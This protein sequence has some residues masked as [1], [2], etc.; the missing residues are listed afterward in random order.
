MWDLKK[1]AP[2]NLFIKQKKIHNVESKLMVTTGG[3]GRGVGG[4]NCETWTDV[5]TL[6]YIKEVTNKDLWYSTRNTIQYS[7]MAYM[8]IEYKKE[9][10][11]I[12]YY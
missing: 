2:V 8:G 11:S 9:W 5:Y 6:P 10:I 1:M 4:I 12:M 3:R 7:V